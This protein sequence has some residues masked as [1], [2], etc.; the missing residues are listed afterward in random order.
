MDSPRHTPSPVVA[1]P[2]LPNRVPLVIVMKK[3]AMP[4][5]TTASVISHPVIS[6]HAGS[7][8]R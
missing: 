8:K 3:I 1:R 5:A 6:C 2:R 4:H 7:V